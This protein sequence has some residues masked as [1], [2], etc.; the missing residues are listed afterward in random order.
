MSYPKIIVNLKKLENNVKSVVEHCKKENIFVSGVTKV[1][2]GNPEIAQAY[3][4]GG[5]KYLADSRIE[6]LEKMKDLDIEKYML[7]LPMISE[8]D[9]VV[10]YADISL[11]SEY[12]TVV[13]LDKAAKEFNKIHK[14]IMMID[15]G[16]LREGYF[17]E[18]ELLNSVE[19]IIKLENVKIVGI[20]TN[21]A[22]YGGIV[23]EKENIEQME[24][25]EN[26][27]KDK[28]DLDLEIISGGNSATIHL[29]EK[30]MMG[31]VNNLRLGETLT[32]GV[33]PSYDQRI[34]GTVDDVFTIETEIIEIKEKPTYP[35]GKIGK[36][37]F[38]KIPTFEDKGVR[39][40]MICAIGKQDVD[41]DTMFPFD[42]KITIFGG[43][44]DHLILD[45]TDSVIDYKIG[46]KVKFKV[47]YVSV[48]RA[49]TSEYV[50]KELVK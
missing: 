29:V 16:D 17:S 20:G 4:D 8:A 23:P 14:I 50:C 43:S 40:R 21:M 38:G 1:F 5:V 30:K 27:L 44:S 7:R 24:Y 10:Q 26:L 35:I 41:L 36:D 25:F 39:K 12:D 22:C 48:L 46:D 34:P 2:C 13:A 33:E 42:E 47:A 18:E 3:V 37:A 49:M 45:V 9:K 11:N 6:N 28:F 31:R 32:I 15:L 19:N